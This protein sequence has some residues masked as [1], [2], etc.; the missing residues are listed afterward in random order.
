MGIIRTWICENSRCRET[1]DSWEPNP[2]CPK[3]HCVRVSWCPAGGHIGG[4]GKSADCELR[5]LADMFS[6]DNM[7]SAERGRAAK[8]VSLPPAPAANPGNVHTFAGG[9]AAA[10][11]P[12]AGAQCV[13][14]A[15]NVDFKA[16]VGIGNKLGPGALGLP[17]MRSNTAVEA[18]HKP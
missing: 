11:N 17:G 6:M 13:P 14:A 15:N 12:A 4:A 1:F 18:T 5:K 10:I 3:V 9:F 16:K 2:E 8:K 7:N